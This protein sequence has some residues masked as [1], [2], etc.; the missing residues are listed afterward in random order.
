MS[1]S[2]EEQIKAQFA[3]IRIANTG[4]TTLRQIFYR[5]IESYDLNF[6]K[7]TDKAHINWRDPDTY[8]EFRYV[9]VLEVRR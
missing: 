4:S 7:P 6:I 9:I 2:G 3:F 5:L 8:G 1:L